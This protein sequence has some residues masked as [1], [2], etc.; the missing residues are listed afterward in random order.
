[1]TV[2]VGYAIVFVSDMARS[3][4]FYESFLGL[5]AAIESPEWSEFQTA[6]AR[7]ALHSA[8]GSSV[9][10]AR[11]DVAGACRPGFRV[12]DLDA[13]HQQAVARAIPCLSAPKEVFG[14]RIAQ[15]RD[16]DDLVLAV[17]EHRER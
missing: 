14:S 3:L 10:R 6:G 11:A 5:K 7:I 13:F 1:M 9:E 15:Y 4:A 16:P 12:P 2:T 8:S 17:S